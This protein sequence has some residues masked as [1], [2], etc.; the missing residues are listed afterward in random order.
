MC[1]RVRVRVRVRVCVCVRVRVR[2]SVRVRVRVHMRVCVHVHVR[3]RVRVHVHVHVHVRMHMRVRVR[4]RGC[5]HMPVQVRVRVRMRVCMQGERGGQ[6]QRRITQD[7]RVSIEKFKYG[8]VHNRACA[9]ACTVV[10]CSIFKLFNRHAY[11]L[12]DFSLYLS[13]SLPHPTS[14]LLSHARFSSLCLSLYDS[15]LFI[16]RRCR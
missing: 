2:V 16:Q 10:Y 1:V 4:G 9:R 5:V 11:V 15:L 8:T 14:I 3:V 7:V 13:P 6:V 12:C